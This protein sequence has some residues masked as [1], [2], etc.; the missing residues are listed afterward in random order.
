MNSTTR[1]DDLPEPRPVDARRAVVDAARYDGMTCERG[2]YRAK[3]TIVEP[4]VNTRPGEHRNVVTLECR[5]SPD[6]A[7]AWVGYIR[8]V[9]IG[10][11]RED[12]RHPT[13][14][15]PGE[16]ALPE[17]EY[18]VEELFVDGASAISLP[19][20]AAKPEVDDE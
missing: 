17:E 20:M 15:E 14:I 12:W 19:G 1:R 16:V 10:E 6:H 9:P 11:L 3:R 4:W 2:A 5:P 7:W 13:P 8:V 18:D